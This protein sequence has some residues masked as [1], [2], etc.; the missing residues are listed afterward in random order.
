MT[1]NFA[2]ETAKYFWKTNKLTKVD[3]I[4]GLTHM[5]T[6]CQKQKDTKKQ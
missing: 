6:F 2:Y 4:N 3:S 1:K 5:T